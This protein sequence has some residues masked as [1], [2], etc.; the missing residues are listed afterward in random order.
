MAVSRYIFASRRR[1]D[2]G[3]PFVGTTRM[4]S[5]IRTNVLSG[6]IEVQRHVIQDGE[7][8]DTLAF[9]FYG[10]SSMWWVIAAASGIG[11]GMQLA[12]GTLVQVP[13]RMDQ[14]MRYIR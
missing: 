11:W 7:R 14:V 6:L 4:T 13:T 1:N 12:P 8:L 5:N 2:N 10:D 9:S 3:L